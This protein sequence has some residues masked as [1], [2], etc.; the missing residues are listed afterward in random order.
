ML[1]AKVAFNLPVEGPFDYIIPAHL[2]KEAKAG[3][4]VWVSFGRKKSAGFIVGITAKTTVR[5]LKLV[6]SLIDKTVLFGRGMLL[7]TRELSRYYCVSWGQMLHA[8]IPGVLQG[9]RPLPELSLQTPA[10]YGSRLGPEPE[11][12]LVC[13]GKI[14]ARWDIYIEAINEALAG[15]KTAIVL[16]PNID[17]LDRAKDLLASRINSPI[18]GLYR[19]R[20]DELREWVRIKEGRVNIVVSTRSGIFAPLKNLG[21]II[22]DEEENSSYKQD[23]SPHYHARQ[24]AFARAKI[25]GARVI[26]G[27]ASPSLES[28]YLAKRNKIKILRVREEK[29][30]PEVKIINTGF[31]HGMGAGR[32]VFSKY[33]QDAIAESLGRKEK[34]LLFLNRRGFATFASCGRCNLVLRCPRCS[35][36]L[37]FHSAQNILNC[38]YCNFKMPAPQICPNCNAGYIRYSG[39][40][41]EKIES[42]LARI[43]PQAVPSDITVATA[44]VA[45]KR[46][47]NFALVGLLSIDNSLNRADFRAAEKTFNLVVGFAGMAEKKIIIQTALPSHHCFQALVKADAD[48]F[49]EEEL[50]QRKQLKFPPYQHIVLVKMRA[51][52]PQRVEDGACAL[53]NQFTR[54]NRDRA[55]EILSVNPAQPHKLRGKFYWQILLKAASVLKLTGFLKSQLSIF[56]HSGIIVTVDVDPL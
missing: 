50:R 47:Y 1:Y 19:N 13:A 23:Q 11:N 34:I 27:S 15:N 42:E 41:T 36:N 7:L 10:E 6:S 28:L 8:A 37:V 17:A 16:L 55:I 26:L 45:G 25:E 2:E 20:P 54:N 38:H 43:F 5:N 3:A 12:L 48:I 14:Q 21:V 30:L 35:V 44:S 52:N 39:S 9:G 4:R 40:G 18:A 53:F 51:L 24:A 32:S 29:R 22:I 56:K 33:L 31:I 46:K 49:Y